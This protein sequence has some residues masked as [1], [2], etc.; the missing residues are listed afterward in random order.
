MNK[1]DDFHSRVMTDVGAVELGLAPAPS[2]R[3]FFLLLAMALVVRPSMAVAWNAEDATR[4][5][6]PDSAAVGLH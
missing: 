6:S 2:E 1:E 4:T 3:L 5:T